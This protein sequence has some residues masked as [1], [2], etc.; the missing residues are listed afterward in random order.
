[1]EL[2]V[3]KSKSTTLISFLNPTLLIGAEGRQFEDSLLQS[4]DEADGQYLLDLEN[5]EYIEEEVIGALLVLQKV[6]NQSGGTLRLTGIRRAVR[7]IVEVLKLRDFFE[8]VDEVM[9]PMPSMA[10]AAAV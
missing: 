3:T 8:I 1:M 7:I 10:T 6:L 5:V 4:I 2:Q 9:P